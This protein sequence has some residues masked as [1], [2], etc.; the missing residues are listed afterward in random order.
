MNGDVPMRAN[1]GQNKSRSALWHDLRRDKMLYLLLVPVLTTYLVYKY[2]PM[3]GLVIAFKDYNIFQGV[4]ASPWVGLETFKEMAANK[5]FW[6]AVR[7]TF[8]LNIG[9]LI[10]SFPAPIILALM[11][12]EVLQVR[13][14]RVVQSLVYIPHFI[15]W[16]VLGGIMVVLL[17]ESGVVNHIVEALG[18]SKIGFLTTPDNWIA[19]YVISEIWKTMG[20]GS[21]IYLGAITS[22]DPGIYESA[23]IDG[24]N[25]FRQIIH[26]TL[27]FLKPTIL[28][29]LIL[30]IG[31]I[32]SIGFEKPFMLGN[33]LVRN[34]AD[35]ISTHVYDYGVINTRYSY[36]TAVGLC[37]SIINL[38]LI[39]AANRLSNKLT[40]D[41]IW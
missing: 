25:K 24:A 34:V 17:S 16:V 27:P 31:Q 5:Y 22:I 37:Q 28:L 23:M 32:A 4:F 20:W 33:S 9:A 21:I 26:I 35:V 36:S 3:F 30:N 13:T 40:G 15:S 38:V 41:S 19:V 39:T 1:S 2:I 7:N 12:N 8:V 14:R 29:L 11:I 18:G 10:F 6:L